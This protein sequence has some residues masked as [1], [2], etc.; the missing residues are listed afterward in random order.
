VLDWQSQ[1]LRVPIAGAPYLLFLLMLLLPAP[2]LVRNRRWARGDDLRRQTRRIVHVVT[3]FAVGHSLTLALG[4]L[5]LVSV[6]TRLVEGLIAASILVSGVHALRPVVRGGEVAIA[7]GF[8]LMHGLAFAGVLGELGLG[9][10]S[11]VTELLGFN[12]G[13]E[14]T[15]LL[16]V[17]LV[18]PSL[19][20]LARSRAY[21]AVRTGLATVGIVLACGWLAE[22]TGLTSGDPSAVA[23][24]ALVE[25]WWAL[26]FALALAVA[27]TLVARRRRGSAPEPCTAPAVSEAV[28]GPASR[29]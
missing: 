21:P 15:Q 4:A 13:I 10:S 28:P 5:G 2:L 1:T 24:T 7:V 27:A 26:P 18:M 23:S 14:L 12:L 20:V 19:L 22:R 11:L 29:S 8:G 6:P 25:R 9:R 16:V 17:A 3:A